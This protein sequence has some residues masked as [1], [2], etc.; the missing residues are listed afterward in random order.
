MTINADDRW[1]NY[2][3]VSDNLC[4]AHQPGALNFHQE[5]TTAT[6]FSN[7]QQQRQQQQQQLG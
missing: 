2:V 3:H 6:L 4:V 1:P 5:S 7:S